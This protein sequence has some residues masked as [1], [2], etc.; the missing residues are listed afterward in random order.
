MQFK[1]AAPCWSYCW[2]CQKK[3]KVFSHFLAFSCQRGTWPYI[4]LIDHPPPCVSVGVPGF[5]T[6]QKQS[7]GSSE[8]ISQRGLEE[9]RKRRSSLFSLKHRNNSKTIYTSPC[10]TPIQSSDDRGN[11]WSP[12]PSERACLTAGKNQTCQP[13]T[14]SSG[15]N[16]E[17]P[18]T[19]DK[20][21][22]LCHS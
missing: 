20:Q 18:P 2:T 3:I 5:S 9:Q 6:C 4:D 15:S 12:S 1:P 13:T 8:F 14:G 16:K 11:A 17:H 22:P 19:L 10:D 21:E 7:S